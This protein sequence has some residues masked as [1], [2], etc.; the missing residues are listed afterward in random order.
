MKKIMIIILYFSIL[1]QCFGAKPVD[2][3][4]QLKSVSGNDTMPVKLTKPDSNESQQE[5][6]LPPIETFVL[7]PISIENI[8]VLIPADKTGPDKPCECGRRAAEG[9]EYTCSFPAAS[10]THTKSENCYALRATYL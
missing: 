4:E 1:S 7:S 9:G 6:H 3:G 8:S 2:G 5:L 10:V